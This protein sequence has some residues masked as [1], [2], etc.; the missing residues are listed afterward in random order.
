LLSKKGDKIY[1]NLTALY[2]KDGNAV[3]AATSQLVCEGDLIIRGTVYLKN[4]YLK[5]GPGGCRMYVTD[6]VFI[7]GPI[8]SNQPGGK[9]NL[10]I[11]SARGIF[12][13]FNLF[14]LGVSQT[15]DLS[16]T[17][18]SD[19]IKNGLGPQVRYDN[20]EDAALGCANFKRIARVLDGEWFPGPADHNKPLFDAIAVDARKV[21]RIMKDSTD[22][23]YIDNLPP[24]TSLEACGSR[25]RLVLPYSGLL[26]NG[27]VIQSS[28]L[29]QFKGV[30]VGEVAA[31]PISH[32][33][34]V[35][36]PMFADVK[37]ILP[38]LVNPILEVK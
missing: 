27:P 33:N 24:G 36:D 3:D 22:P 38:R 18:T 21:G 12:M 14:R 1:T 31:A 17:T 6:S 28:Y 11:S 23:S 7:E 8:T 25:Q 30:I 19:D 20:H 26:L 13:G 29:G 32:F 2:D 15:A 35:Y 10:Q 9:H 5:T 4:L 34:F 37:K 16:D